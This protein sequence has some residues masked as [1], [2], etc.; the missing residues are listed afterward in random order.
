M[1]HAGSGIAPIFFRSCIFSFRSFA[2][3]GTSSYCTSH[4]AEAAALIEKFGIMG[5]AALAEKAIPNCNIV[6][7][8]GDEMKQAAAGF[9]QVLFDANPKSVGGKLPD[10][11]FYYS[12]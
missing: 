6:F 7:M 4:T 5:S 2:S 3:N 11:A 10:D 9:Y 12:R 1:S 8:E